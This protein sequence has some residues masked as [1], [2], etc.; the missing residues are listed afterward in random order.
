MKYNNPEFD[1]KF[2]LDD[3]LVRETLNLIE[4]LI[5]KKLNLELESQDDLKI[6]FDNPELIID[7]PETVEKIKELKELIIGMSDIYYA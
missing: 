5:G 1:K 2:K 7:N 3:S 6:L 4:N